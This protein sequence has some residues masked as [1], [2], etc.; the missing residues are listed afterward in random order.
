[1]YRLQG[2]DCFVVGRSINFSELKVNDKN[3]DIIKDVLK[4]KSLQKMLLNHTD[5]TIHMLFL[6]D[7]EKNNLHDISILLNDTSINHFVKDSS[8]DWHRR[9]LF[10]CHT[11]YNSIHRVIEDQHSNGKIQVNVVDSSHISVEML[12]KNKEL[13]PANF[14]NIKADATVSTSFD[15]LVVGFSEVGQD[16][17]RFLYEFGAFVKHHPYNSKV[18]RSD[19]NLHVVDRHMDDL[20]GPFVAA[21]PA[22]NISMPFLNKCERDK[23]YETSSDTSKT[24]S[25]ITF[26][27]MDCRS[28]EFFLHLEKWI[29]SLNYVVL[30]TDDDELNLSLGVRIFKTAVKHRENLK[31]LC[32]LVR[33]HNDDD[34]HLHRVAEHYNR[35]WLAQS[36]A[37]SFN[38]K[39]HRQTKILRDHPASYPIHIFGL[40]HETYTYANII[41]DTIEKEA[42][43]YKELYEASTNQNY[44][45]PTT[46]RDYAW[47]KDIADKLDPCDK[48]GEIHYAPSYSGIMALRRM[49]SQD[50]ANSMHKITKLI[51]A[52][53]AIEAAGLSNVDWTS[54]VRKQ[55]KVIYTLQQGNEVNP[56]LVNILDTLAQTEHLRWN[57]SHQLL[58]YIQSGIPPQEDEPTYKHEGKL[59]HSCIVDWDKLSTSIQ[60]YD[61]NVVDV[62]LDIINNKRPQKK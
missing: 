53:K 7:N 19:F 9:V 14:V 20:A 8:S 42:I 28:V 1:M 22:I 24:T 21:A 32:I 51:L 55:E 18:E 29:K 37:S 17:V 38:G 10:Y 49:Q 4:L 62:S 61:Y 33:A 57:A 41:D 60:S 5:N 44:E 48:N 13:L 46:H 25:P 12:K 34:G 23:D 30:A 45:K 2:A 56:L 6:S 59:H 52:G 27:K 3:K 43:C 26:H 40:S 15:S 47:N 54:L 35:L 11:R 16:S 58:G 31:D 50:I 39:D 36:N